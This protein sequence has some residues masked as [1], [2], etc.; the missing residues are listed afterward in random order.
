LTAF[1]CIPMARHAAWGK[2]RRRMLDIDLLIKENNR[3]MQQL[4]DLLNKYTELED[5]IK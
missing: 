4:K 5:R 3:L 2:E 1:Y